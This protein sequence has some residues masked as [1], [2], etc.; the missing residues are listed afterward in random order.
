MNLTDLHEQTHRRF[1]PLTGQWVVVSPRRLER[2]WQGA[3][4]ER[5]D[6]RLPAYDPSCYL[7][8]G[9]RRASGKSNPRYSGTF[10]FDNDFP[11][12]SQS[13]H[14]TVDSDDGIFRARGERGICRV[15]C[16]NPRHDLTLPLMDVDGI[17]SVVEAWQQQTEELGAVPWVQHV[18]IFENKGELMGCSN[19]HPHCQIWATESLPNEPRSELYF[20][21]RFFGQNGDCLLCR[22]VREERIRKERIV[23]ETSHFITVV[24]YWA[25]WP[26]ETLVMPKTHCGRLTLLTSEQVQDLAVCLQRMTIRYDNL[27]QTSFPYTMGF[28]QA[29]FDDESHPEWHL[30]A[31]FYPPLLRSASVR[32]FM[33]GFELLGSP[34]RDIT[35][36]EAA[37]RLRDLPD[38]HYRS[39]LS[40][41]ST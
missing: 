2:P 23:L 17:R 29:P 8:P 32:K 16:F 39:P 40:D 19:P 14:G 9:N 22:Y 38:R 10:A 11:G 3:V 5:P 20:Q 30:H 13:S 25:I 31:H 15:L 27:F 26:F 33:V 1:N 18:Q 24:P 28:H 37:K 35:P 7:C 36:E 6:P 41:L 12:L 34:Q 4:E 21:K